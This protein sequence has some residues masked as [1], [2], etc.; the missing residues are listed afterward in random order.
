MDRKAFPVFLEGERLFLA[1]LSRQDAPLYAGWLNDEEVA[2]FLNL[3]RPITLDEEVEI[4]DSMLRSPLS[5]AVHAAIWVRKPLHLI[6]NVGL[7]KIKSIDRHAMIGLFIGDV[8]EWDKGYG[9][10]AMRIMAD[11]AF[12]TLNLRK[13][14]L[15]VFGHNARA[16]RCYETVGFREVGRYR[17]HRFIKGEWRDQIIMELFRDDFK[18]CE[19][20]A[21]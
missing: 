1:P 11:Y 4:L 12:N 21:S 3:H 2:N 19:S 13:I 8:Q 6:G 18:A 16:I 17:E 20:T 14:H 9:R 10:E 7:M 15:N 5:V